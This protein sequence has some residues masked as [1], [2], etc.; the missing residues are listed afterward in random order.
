M[1]Y[2]CT[3]ASPKHPPSRVLGGAHREIRTT[4]CSHGEHAGRFELQVRLITGW[5]GDRARAQQSPTLRAPPRCV[6]ISTSKANPFASRLPSMVITPAFRFAWIVSSRFA[7]SLRLVCNPALIF[8]SLPRIAVSSRLRSR[9]DGQL[10]ALAYRVVALHTSGWLPLN[11]RDVPPPRPSRNHA[12]Y[13]Q[14]TT[15]T[16]R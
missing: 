15:P 13:K 4:R 12:C 8:S 16:F 3:C 10:A 7:N 6:D 2:A 11:L 9:A 14:K 5:A 1:C